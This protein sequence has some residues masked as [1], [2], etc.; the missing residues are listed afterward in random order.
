MFELQQRFGYRRELAE[1]LA[2]SP[3]GEIAELLEAE[4][5]ALDREIDELW[6]RLLSHASFI[7]IAIARAS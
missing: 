3:W 2:E 7:V 6:S 5:I 4:R 1:L